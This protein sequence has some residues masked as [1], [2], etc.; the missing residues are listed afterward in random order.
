MAF[1]CTSNAI[2]TAPI[3]PYCLSSCSPCFPCVPEDRRAGRRGWLHFLLSERE[4]GKN[5][6]PF[7]CPLLGLRPAGIALNPT[8]KLRSLRSPPI[9]V[10]FGASLN[11]FWSQKRSSQPYFYTPHCLAHLNSAFACMFEHPKR[12]RERERPTPR[13]TKNSEYHYTLSLPV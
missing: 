2:R 11:Y 5:S 4:N 7:A 6:N 3:W 10:L 9:A 13:G 8:S 12:E 1:M